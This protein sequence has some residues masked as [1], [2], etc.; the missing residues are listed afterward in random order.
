M[1]RAFETRQ[2]R[3]TLA[4]HIAHQPFGI[5][6]GARQF[7]HT[8]TIMFEGRAGTSASGFAAEVASKEAVA[9][10]DY[11]ALRSGPWH[12]PKSNYA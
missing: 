2:F 8:K 12:Q 11:L 7:H 6:A 3:H 4:W 1:P 10:L 9:R 5:V